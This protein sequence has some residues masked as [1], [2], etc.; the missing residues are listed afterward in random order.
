MSIEVTGLSHTY[1][2]GTPLRKQALDGVSLSFGAGAWAAVVGHTGSGKSTLAQYLNG[3]LVPEEGGGDV[4]VD[5]ISLRRNRKKLREVR[6][7]VGLVFQYPEQQLFAET[8]YDEIAFA[9]RNWKVPESRIRELVR[10]SMAMLELPATIERRSPF[11]LSGGQKR[12]VAIASVL[13]ADPG[14]IVLDEPTAGLDG[15]GKR[16][17]LNL[18]GS[19]VE[20]GTGLI[21][22]THDLEVALSRCSVLHILAGGRLSFSGS[23]RD[24]MERMQTDP[25]EGLV[26]PPV[27]A[28]SS[29]LHQRGFPV[30]LTLDPEQLARAL[31]R[32][33]AS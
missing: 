22:I 18:L 26:M 30:P 16:S 7:K 21:H 14:Y 5:G 8:V 6:R 28:V 24:V 32:G 31:V 27:L 23:A 13:A 33:R 29:C 2:P 10:R 19:L 3:L 11:F 25:P 4:V 15:T 1:H 9:P 12:R 17:L 20:E